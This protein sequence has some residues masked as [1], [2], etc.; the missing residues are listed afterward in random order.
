MHL[1]TLAAAV[2]IVTQLPFGTVYNLRDRSTGYLGRYVDNPLAVDTQMPMT[3]PGKGGVWYSREEF[4]R[5]CAD[6]LSYGIDGFVSSSRRPGWWFSLARERRA[7]G[8]CVN[9]TALALGRPDAAEAV[10]AAMSDPNGLRRGGKAD[11]T[12]HPSFSWPTF[13]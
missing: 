9:V 13:R 12:F 6:I 5:T 2:A 7:A 1:H 10:K 3:P 4:A 11:T 8:N